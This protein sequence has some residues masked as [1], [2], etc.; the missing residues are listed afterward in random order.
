MF[1]AVFLKNVVRK[2]QAKVGSNVSGRT[3]HLKDTTVRVTLK[4]ALGSL[5]AK[6]ARRV[7]AI[8][9]RELRELP[10]II[11]LRRETAVWR[12]GVRYSGERSL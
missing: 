1:T 3:L 8:H 9:L 10:F 11:Q 7:F 5:G 12:R 2:F 6:R 4:D